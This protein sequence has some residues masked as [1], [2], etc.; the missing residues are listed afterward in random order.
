M[1]PD[2]VI[3]IPVIR[4]EPNIGNRII[5]LA[6]LLGYLL[7]FIDPDVESQDEQE[8]KLGKRVDANKHLFSSYRD[9]FFALG[10]RNYFVHPEDQD[11][12]YSDSEKVRSINHLILAIDEICRHPKVPKDIVSEIYRD[13]VLDLKPVPKKED[14][15]DKPNEVAKKNGFRGVGCL[16]ALLIAVLIFIGIITSNK[17]TN[18][19]L[20]TE[21]MTPTQSIP[22]RP[23]VY[24]TWKT[25]NNSNFGFTIDW[26][27]GW[28][29]SEEQKENIFRT[30][31][32]LPSSSVSILLD[33][34]V[35]VT[36]SSPIDWWQKFSRQLQ[37]SYGD[38]DQLISIKESS[39]DGKNAAA[40]LFN[41]E[42]KDEPN[43]K[44]LALPE[45]P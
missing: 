33:I 28:T 1:L 24:P 37:R 11:R 45:L 42:R 2:G 15:L 23:Q 36:E 43:L 31:F 21:P 8:I 17:P 18:N 7:K 40:W 22:V 27:N 39:L 10:V 35:G 34:V 16:A 13:P 3:P 6:A 25:H 32:K 30:H 19:T 29:M 41:L 12:I 44:K 20:D 14:K 4:R 5:N 26:P 38:R 9:V